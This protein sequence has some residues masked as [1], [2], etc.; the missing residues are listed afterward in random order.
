MRG[1]FSDEL[2]KLRMELLHIT[3]LLELELDF[4]EEDVE[5]AD[6]SELRS[7]AIGIDTLISRLCASFS[8]GNVIKNGIPVAIVGNTNV[9]KKYPTQRFAKRRSCH[10]VR[11]RGYH[12]RRDRG[13]HQPPGNH[14]PFYRCGR[15][16]P[17]RRPSRKYM[18][19]ERTFTKNRTSTYRIVFNRCHQ[20]HG[21]IS[22]LLYPSE[23]TSRTGYPLSHFTQQD[24]PN[25]FCQHDLVTNHISII[26]TESKS[27]K[28]Q[29]NL[30][31]IDNQTYL[32][33]K[34]TIKYCINFS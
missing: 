20:K 19:I 21:T 22:S 12:S 31:N 18:G 29:S 32:N 26:N 17:H 10:R 28:K 25:R 1:G 2:M 16:P 13:Y 4:S 5:F 27:L 11:H 34:V 9:G 7:I 14:F 23:R 3:S 8:L 24:R 15:H 33:A 30:D 6:R